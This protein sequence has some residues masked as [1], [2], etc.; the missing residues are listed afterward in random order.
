M[1]ITTTA[2]AAGPGAGATRPVFMK[3]PRAI[4]MALF[5]VAFDDAYPTGGEAWNAEAESGFSDVIA[6]WVAPTAGFTFE[7]VDSATAASRKI[8]AYWVDTTVDGAAMA[9]VV[10]TTD[11]NAGLTA[12]NV[13]VFGYR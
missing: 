12:V 5:T 1:G 2:I 13:V 10:D 3:S 4:E 9:E 7:Y 11:I 8:K 6:V